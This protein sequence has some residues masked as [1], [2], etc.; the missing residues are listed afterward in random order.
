MTPATVVQHKDF[1]SVLDFEAAEFERCVGLAAQVKRVRA[2]GRE[3][4]MADAL[5][6]RQREIV[7]L[8]YYAGL[9]YGEI[10]HALRISTGTV[11]ATLNAARRTLRTEIEE[12]PT[13]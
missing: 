7:F 8:H 12:V 6:G 10:A 5:S 1:L 13:C 2:L 4:P 9:G 11:G 3:A